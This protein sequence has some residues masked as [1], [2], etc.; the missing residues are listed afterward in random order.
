MGLTSSDSLLAQSR[1]ISKSPLKMWSSS[2]PVSP[3]SIRQR[4]LDS[5][6]G[7]GS[8][9]NPRRMALSLAEL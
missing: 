9:L 8:D 1:I 5:V 6:T 2:K 7:R 4:Y 3:S